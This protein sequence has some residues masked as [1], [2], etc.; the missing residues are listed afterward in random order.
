M[1]ILNVTGNVTNSAGAVTPFTG[2]IVVVD[3]AVVHSVVVAPPEGIAGTLFTITVNAHDTNVP[4]RTPLVYGV[5]VDGVPAIATGIAGQ[6]TYQ[7]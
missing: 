2:E 4:P 1:S 6:F 3:G 7:S 5:S